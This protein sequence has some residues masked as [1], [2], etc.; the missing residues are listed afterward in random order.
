MKFPPWVLL[1][2]GWPTKLFFLVVC[3][4]TPGFIPRNVMSSDISWLE[5]LH[6]RGSHFVVCLAPEFGQGIFLPEVSE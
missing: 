6:S 2:W 3:H 5:T 1:E 4:G